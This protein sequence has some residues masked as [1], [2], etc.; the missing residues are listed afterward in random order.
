MAQTTLTFSFFPQMG[1][2]K[3]DCGKGFAEDD[4]VMGKS[5]SRITADATKR[6]AVSSFL[7]SG[8]GTGACP[9]CFVRNS[10]IDGVQIERLVQ[11]ERNHDELNFQRWDLLRARCMVHNVKRSGQV[12]SVVG[13]VKER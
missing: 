6:M 5:S 12:P 2:A 10:K 9:G 3:G 8:G 7:V 4:E 1:T 11:I 13:G